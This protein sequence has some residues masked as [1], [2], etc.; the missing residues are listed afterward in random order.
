MRKIKVG[1]FGAGRGATMVAVMAQHP[2]AH[3]I[4]DVYQALDMT[5]PGTLGYRS[6][7]NGNVPIDI[8]NFRNKQ[9][10]EKYR[11]DRWCCDPKLAGKGQPKYSCSGGEVKVPDS[12]Y[13]KQQQQCPR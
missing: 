9:I 12:V 4:I 1:V 5:L 11:T 13:R 10:R 8:P 6:I 3:H 7:V 2:E